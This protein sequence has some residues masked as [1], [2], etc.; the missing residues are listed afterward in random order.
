MFGICVG[1]EYS[2]GGLL[3]MILC[4][5][6]IKNCELAVWVIKYSLER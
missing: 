1:T 4:N 6:I 2:K 3:N 5:S